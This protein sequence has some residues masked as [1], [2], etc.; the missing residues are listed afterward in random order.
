MMRI[1]KHLVFLFLVVG[2]IGP[3]SVARA[4]YEAFY[5]SYAGRGVANT[6]GELSD[7]DLS[8]EIRPAKKGKGF[9][10]AWSTVTRRGKD[11]VRRKAY[12]VRF[13]PTSRNNVFS[14]A[15]RINMFGRAVPLDPLKGD[16]FVWAV[17]Q[18]KTLKVHA[19]HVTDDYGYEMQVYERT[20]TEAGMDV[21][22]SRVRDGQRLRD[23]TA[24]LVR[25][26]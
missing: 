3:H 16:P 5:G 22:F 6:A 10:V 18:G 25:V 24:K 12:R 15:M 21:R 13:V 9:V 17:V 23:V 19:M 2:V 26:P 14:S 4:D 11:D 1:P 7:R 8:V 20:L